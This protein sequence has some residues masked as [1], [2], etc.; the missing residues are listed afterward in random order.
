MIDLIKVGAH[1]AVSSVFEEYTEET[2]IFSYQVWRE[3]FLLLF[4]GEMR[5]AIGR[6]LIRSSVT[7]QSDLLTFCTLYFGG[8]A[9]NSGVRSFRG[10]T[11]YL[12]MKKEIVLAFN[13]GD[14]ATIIRRM[15]SHF[16]KHSYSLRNLFRDE[17]RHIL[18]HILAGTLLEFEDKFTDLYDKSRSLAGFLRETGMPVPHRFMAT[19]ETALNLQLQ[20]L[21][22]TEPIDML[23]LRE[24]V[25]EIGIWKV[26]VDKVA[27]EFIIRRRLERA[28]AEIKKE[29][30]STQRLAEVYLLL[31]AI[32]ILAI[33]VTLWEVQ[34][35]YWD[36]LQ[37][38]IPPVGRDSAR[39][40]RVSRSRISRSAASRSRP[41]S[42]ARPRARSSPRALPCCAR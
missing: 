14:V 8:H 40:Y 9:L 42:S 2:G 12:S 11:A 26:G 29:P 4:A 6:V 18:Q 23:K 7:R 34:N 13:D 25:D 5:L 38:A 33:E 16:G 27:L 17:Q 1:Y 41:A 28:M 30:E 39:G 31:E 21:V 20:K 22:T 37:S 24:T 19:A 35:Q 3:D 15:D 36:L 10:E 32:A